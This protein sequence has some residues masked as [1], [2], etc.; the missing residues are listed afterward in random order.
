LAEFPIEKEVDL[1]SFE[2][3]IE[4]SVPKDFWCI[5][6]LDIDKDRI[7]ILGQS[8][9]C[10]AC[11]ILQEPDFQDCGGSCEWTVK[12]NPGVYLLKLHPWSQKTYDGDYDGG[13]NVTSVECLYTIPPKYTLQIVEK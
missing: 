12:T 3:K 8:D 5:V 10:Q 4:S 9:D 1:S 11:D 2:E 13:V 7:W 6:A